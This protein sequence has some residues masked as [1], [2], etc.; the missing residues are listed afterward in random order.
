MADTDDRDASAWAI[1]LIGIGQ[2]IAWGSI[3]YTMT[4]L[5]V[6]MAREFGVSQ[7]VVFAALSAGLFASGLA[8]PLAGRLID[9]RGGRFVLASGSALAA[10]GLAT[11]AGAPNI[12]VYF[13]GW[14][15]AGVA[16]AF[17]L[18]DPAFATVNQ[19]APR[20][21]RRAVTFVTLLGGFASTVFW[22][23]TQWLNDAYGWRT[24]MAIY[25]GV[26]L[27]VSMPMHAW[28]VPP[29]PARALTRPTGQP[30]E[31]TG[32]VTVPV[33]RGL[34]ALTLAFALGQF[35][36]AAV[37][38]HVLNVLGAGGIEAGT[39]VWIGALIGPMQVV[40][41]IVEFTLAGRVRARSVGLASFGLMALSLLLFALT[42]PHV[43]LA[44]IF[45]IIILFAIASSVATAVTSGHLEPNDA[46]RTL[47][48]ELF[49]S[50]FV[51]VMIGGLLALAL[52]VLRGGGADV[53]VLAVCLL[54][55]EVGRRIHFDPLLLMLSAGVF[56]EN[57]A[58]AGER[59][60]HS[61][62]DASLPVFIIFF[63]VVGASI[64][65]DVLSVVAIPALLLA[66]V[67]G[68]GLVVGTRVAAT[69]AGAPASVTRFAGLGLLP[70]AGLANALAILVARTFPTIGEAIAALLLGIVALN[71]VLTPVL[72]RAALVRSGEIA[73]P[74]PI[75]PPPSSA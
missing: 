37:G 70:Q 12:F 54:G 25:A 40:G 72:F 68:A 57:V 53:F 75:V 13:I 26:H 6:P 59:L 41:R 62:E 46:L 3:Y 38:V 52:R 1:A 48:W 42:G 45:V 24:T 58:R 63:T 18:Y 28:L 61:Y 55:A 74:M 2:V 64:R 51:G 20:N 10:V 67:R 34:A 36:T 43:W 30:L 33:Q 9:E 66:A 32:R 69:I 73:G 19:I 56:V 39:A 27:L 47:A 29:T 17:C 65:L 49:G 8:A 22:P 60:R 5:G 15:I 4:V 31:P 50:V 11:I 16:M 23:L 44:V 35:I 71:A 21:F 7:A 14:A